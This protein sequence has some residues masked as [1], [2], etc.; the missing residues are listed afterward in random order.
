M[1]PVTIQGFLGLC[2]VCVTHTFCNKR[3]QEH[4]FSVKVAGKRDQPRTGESGTCEEEPGT[5]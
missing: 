3:N 5:C 2:E 1:E 4:A